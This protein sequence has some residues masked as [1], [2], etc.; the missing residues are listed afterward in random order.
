MTLGPIEQIPI[1][2]AAGVRLLAVHQ[3]VYE[4]TDGRIGHRILGVPCLLLRTVG[5]K[6][7]LTRTNSLT[8]GRDGSDYLVVASKGGAPKAP[9]WYHNLRANPSAEIQVGTRKQQV[10]ARFVVP[11]DDEYERLWDIVNAVNSNRFRAYQKATTRPIPV[12]VL[13]PR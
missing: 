13:T 9:G 6:T 4:R 7:G 2:K 12:V 11:G 5:A 3:W 8:Y 1:V 10:T